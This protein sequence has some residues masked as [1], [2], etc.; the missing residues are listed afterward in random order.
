MTVVER[1]GRWSRC[2]FE[3]AVDGD[4][5]KFEDVWRPTSTLLPSQVHAQADHLPME[6]GTDQTR[7]TRAALPP[8]PDGGATV[9]RPRPGDDTSGPTPNFDTIPH[10]QGADPIREP[11]RPARERNPPERLAYSVAALSA[12]QV[13]LA[14]AIGRGQDLYVDT[15]GGAE[16]FV[17]LASAA[18]G[19]D[20]E[21]LHASFAALEPEHQRAACLMADYHEIGNELGYSSPQASLARK[22]YAA[23][24]VDA[25]RVGLRTEPLDPLL[26]AIAPHG[27][28]GLARASAQIVDS[29]CGIGD[30][31]D[32]QYDGFL[33]AYPSTG[34]GPDLAFAAKKKSSSDIFTERQMR[35]PEWDEPKGIEIG[36]LERLGAMTP[37]SADDPVVKGMKVVDTMWAGRCKRKPDLTID[38]YSARC[39]LRGDLHSRSYGVDAN[40]S[41]SPVVRNTSMMSIDAV[42]VLRRQH[43]RPYDVTGAY[44]H[45]QQTDSEQVLARPPVGFR[46]YDERGVELLWLMWVPLY[47]QTDAGAIWNRTVNAVFTDKL[48]YERS[49]NDPCV[50][51][52]DVG[53]SGDRITMPLYV[54]DGRWYWDD[55]VSADAE[56]DM[57]AFARE[58]EV[59]FGDTDPSEDYFLGGN[60]IS[61]GRDACTVRCTTYIDN[62][63]KRYADGD[64]SPCKRYPAS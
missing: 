13:E 10:E 50:Y 8:S 26:D 27:S 12:S 56:A 61:A 14:Q 38:K 1:K 48:G 62:M 30:I 32:E 34:I 42:S 55:A 60:R 64:V 49:S 28:S 36:K 31:F 9:L 40:R 25:A 7:R 21:S 58:F 57:A 5:S 19:G 15:A 59:R 52:R 41:M 20:A 24:M 6:A 51:S 23:T 45:G 35:G 39:V 3:H 43:M 53:E 17:G 29:V 11:T 54:D 22:L 2:R 63:V 33:F 44:L 16:R 47:G 46:Q 18:G 4:G 37:I